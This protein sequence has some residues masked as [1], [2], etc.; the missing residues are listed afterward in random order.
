[1]EEFGYRFFFLIEDFRFKVKIFSYKQGTISAS[2]IG[3]LMGTMVIMG[4]TITSHGVGT[5]TGTITMK[6]II[7]TTDMV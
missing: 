5:I 2:L 7:G 6:D 1:M 4:A 3:G